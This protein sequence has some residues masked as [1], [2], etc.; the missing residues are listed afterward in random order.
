MKSTVK[1][2]TGGKGVKD[3]DLGVFS[4]NKPKVLYFCEKL[5]D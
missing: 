1:P 3:D 4:I 2:K 5:I